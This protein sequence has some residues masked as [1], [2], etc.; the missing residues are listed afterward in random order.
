MIENI[1]PTKLYFNIAKE[2][3]L[4]NIQLE[5]SNIIKDVQVDYND[6]WGKT[7]KIS[8]LS[9]SVID[10]YNL[11]NLKSFLDENLKEYLK[12]ISYDGNTKYK[13]ESWISL[14]NNNDYGHIHDH[15]TA[16]ISGVYYYKTNEKDG[17][18]VFYN[19]V[20]QVDMSTCFKKESWIHQPRIGK[21]LLFPGFLKHGIFRNETNDKRISF[22]FNIFFN[23]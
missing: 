18:I 17:D 8:S 13:M 22:S 16:D 19:P 1:F 12:E 9:K 15:G 14:F 21:M 3:Q 7:H 4:S 20:I 11:K 6:E 10:H 2:K 5:I 23:K